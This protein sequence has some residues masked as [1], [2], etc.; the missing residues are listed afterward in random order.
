MDD[1][2]ALDIIG[3][4]KLARV[5][6]PRTWRA[7]EKKISRGAGL[8]AEELVYVSSM[9]RTYGRAAPRSR[10]LHVRLGEHDE[11]P[12]CASCGEESEFYCNMNDAYYCTAHLVGHDANERVIQ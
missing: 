9:A 8:D 5:G 10:I 7:L 2:A 3:R 11:R 4:L 12:V 6:E 1:S